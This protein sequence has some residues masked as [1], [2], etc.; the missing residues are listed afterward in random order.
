MMEIS[1]FMLQLKS[2]FQEATTTSQHF[3]WGD[4]TKMGKL[5]SEKESLG[6]MK[7]TPPNPFVVK[8]GFRLLGVSTTKCSD[9]SVSSRVTSRNVVT[10]GRSWI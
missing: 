7:N 9:E 1:S 8:T 5:D 2:N 3:C 4:D 6:K 10:N